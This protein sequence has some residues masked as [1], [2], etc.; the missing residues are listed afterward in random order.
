MRFR[1]AGKTPGEERPVSSGPRKHVA[2]GFGMCDLSKGLDEHQHSAG[3]HTLEVRGEQD[4][5]A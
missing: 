5:Q 1:L 2:D 4:V 3:T